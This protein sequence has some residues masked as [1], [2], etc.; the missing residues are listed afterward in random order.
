MPFHRMHYCWGSGGKGPQG[1][2][3]PQ[4]Q[5][6]NVVSIF[7]STTPLKIQEEV[8]QL[9]AL[10]TKHLQAYSDLEI[11]EEVA[12]WVPDPRDT[13]GRKSQYLNSHI[14]HWKMKTL[15]GRVLKEYHED[16]KNTILFLIKFSRFNATISL[17]VSVSMLS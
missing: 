2:L 13:R 6:Q 3:Q 11:Q 14:L 9:E 16:Y 17:V 7:H 4:S 12:N 1:R 15:L 8:Y 10:T 5:A